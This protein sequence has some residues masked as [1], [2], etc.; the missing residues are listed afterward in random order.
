LGQAEILEWETDGMLV[1]CGPV[2]ENCLGVA[3]L[4]RSEY[5]IRLGVINARFVKPLDRRTILKAIK[6]CRF[7]LTVEEAS[8]MGGFGSAVLEVANESGLSTTHVRRLGLPDRYVLHA[9]RDEQLAEV[10]LDVDGIARSVLALAIGV[11]WSMQERKTSGNSKTKEAASPSSSPLTE[12]D[13]QASNE[14]F[15]V[16]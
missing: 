11:G 13:I 8:L 3:R 16:W 12:R 15:W 2:V 1:A 14:Q 4:L 9:E 5:G 10:G 6:E 7:V